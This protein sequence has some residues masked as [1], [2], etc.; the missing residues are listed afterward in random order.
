MYNRSLMYRVSPKGLWM[1]D[2]YNW[3]VGFINY[4]R[5]NSKNISGGGIRC[6]CKRCKNEK[7]HQ[8]RCCYNASSIKKKS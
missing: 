1:I 5:S 8:S 2:Y 7:V 3:V 4:A 6:T